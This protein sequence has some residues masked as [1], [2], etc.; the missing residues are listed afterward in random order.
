MS[1]WL[2]RLWWEWKMWRQAVIQLLSHL[3]LFVT[4]WTA[5]HQ[6]P[7]PT[8]SPGIC[9]NSC[10]LSQW[11]YPTISFFAD[12]F[13]FCIQSFPVLGYFPMSCVF[14][15]GGQSIGASISLSVLPMNIQSWFT[16]GLTGLVF[17]SKGSSRVFSSNHS[18]KASVSS[19]LTLLYDSTLTCINDYWKKTSWTIQTFV[20]K[21]ISLL[22]DMPSWFV[23]AFFSKEQLSFNFMAAVTIYSDF[24]SKENKICHCF[25]FFPIYF[26][27]NSHTRCHDL[28][29]FERW[30]SSQLFHSLLSFSSRGSCW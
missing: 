6:L 23:I 10:P 30:D 29:F 19:V 1:K 4:P 14:T 2:D 5:A 8:L 22:L 9:S 17:Q 3:W 7:C 18:L 27:W 12:P 21:V 15:S 11:C 20:G 25:H 26:P 24:G 28:S 16:L 13:S